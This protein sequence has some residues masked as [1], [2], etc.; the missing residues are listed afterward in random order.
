MKQ[1]R[2]PAKVNK[3]QIVAAVRRFFSPVL[4]WLLSVFALLSRFGA[5]LKHRIRR[6]PARFRMIQKEWIG[7][8][9]PESNRV[10]I[11]LPLF[12]FGMFPMCASLLHEKLHSFRR[13]HNRAKGKRETQL[14]LHL[15]KLKP[16]HFV[17]TAVA[18]AAVAIFFSFFTFGTTVVYN[19]IELETV[20]STRIAKRAAANISDIT[21]ET[22][23]ES[24]YAIS[25]DL[26]HYDTGLVRRRGGEKNRSGARACR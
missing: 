10:L 6:I 3:T 4:L 17:C 19:G 7:N 23:G 8:N 1:R 22:M 21:V 24:S 26:L 13:A 16:I 5:V 15:R 9:F 20:G 25:E 18:V 11:Q 14:R 2:R 12:V